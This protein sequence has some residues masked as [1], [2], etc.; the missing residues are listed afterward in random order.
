VAERRRGI[1][2]YRR[3]FQV[4]FL[5]AFFVLLTLTVWP[6]GQVFLGVFLVGD[7]LIAL[8]TLINGVWLAPMLIAV[9]MLLAPL[10]LGRAFCGYVCPMGTIVE[11]TSPKPSKGSALSSRTRG[12]LR[13]L[14]P[15]TLIVALALSIFASGAFLVFDPLTLL[16]RASTILLY[17]LLDRV[18][19]LAG[20]VAYLAPPLRGTVDAVTGALTGRIVFAEP[21]TFGLAMLTLALF[22]GVL[23]A[24]RLETRLWCRDICPLG[25][26]LGQVGRFAVFG[27]Q[28]DQAAC[29]S[30]GRCAK[31]CPLDAIGS[32]FHSTDC[33]R[34][35][36]GM[37]CADECPE[38]A[39]SLGWLPPKEAYV[40]GR[41][42]FLAATGGAL[43][44]GFLTYTGLSRRT[45]NPGLIRPPG[46]REELDFLALC[47]RCGQCM[48]VC[49][50]NVL[51]PSLAKA[52][53]EGAFTPEMDFR[54]GYCDW[55]CNECG[56]VCPTGAIQALE[57]EAKRTAKIGRAYVDENRCIP[58][59]D[60]QTC[61]VCE[62]LCP[63]P[64]KAVVL[65]EVTVEA[66][67]G[68]EVTLGQ[69]R[70]IDD[71][72]IGCG[73]CEYQCPAQGES[74]IPVRARDDASMRA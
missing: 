59:V 5:L 66:P 36:L 13:K 3:V 73:I 31:V 23:L 46:A 30:C 25:A 62:E 14:P 50:T 53:P 74:A 41:R 52:G 8:N 32:D 19:R 34:C 17:P 20:D 27:R 70:V 18:V 65:N 7:P 26:L 45:R 37:E 12:A 48:K 57:L 11:L 15:Y 42:A 56:K 67:D 49:P 72:C 43:L 63:L 2:S 47:S 69:P 21:L 38:D 55:A 16:T 64:E 9:V 39:I 54:I 33:T 58:F 4:I 35:Q 24:S 10:L 40:P 6:L 61:L 44:V 68:E 22:A 71:L 51:Q 28:V 60:G 1:H 29:I